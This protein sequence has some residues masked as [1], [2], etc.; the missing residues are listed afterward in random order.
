MTRTQEGNGP[1]FLFEFVARS[2][3]LLFQVLQLRAMP[4]FVVRDGR[5]GG[6]QLRNKRRTHL[7]KHL[8]IRNLLCRAENQTSR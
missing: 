8:E 5:L 3:E 1:T 4:R 6:L 2:D 7:F